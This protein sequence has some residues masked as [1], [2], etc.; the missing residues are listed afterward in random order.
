MS[1]LRYRV[2]LE[3]KLSENC[4]FKPAQIWLHKELKISSCC[5]FGCQNRHNTASNYKF[6]HILAA[7]ARHKKKQRQLWLNAIKR[8]EMDRND[9][10]KLSHLQRTLLIR[11]IFNKVL[12]FIIMGR[13]EDLH[14]TE[15]VVYE[16]SVCMCVK[17]TDDLYIII[18]NCMYVVVI[19]CGWKNN[20]AIKIVAC[21]IWNV[22]T[23]S[24]WLDRH[25]EFVFTIHVRRD[26]PHSNSP[27]RSSI[28]WVRV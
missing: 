14:L 24:S 7:T 10:L 21:W 19:N 3:E 26:P 18:C 23:S 12:S 22:F 8:A 13:S 27:V 1:Q 5:D 28:L 16:M 15:Y 17:Q 9:R 25:G 11:N 2:K 20:V 6:D 4:P